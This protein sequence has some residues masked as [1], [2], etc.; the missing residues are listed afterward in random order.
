MYYPVLDIATYLGPTQEIVWA[1]SRSAPDL[2]KEFNS[3]IERFRKTKKYQGLYDKYFVSGRI[4]RIRGSQM[5]S[6][7]H[8][9]ISPYDDLFRKHSKLIDWDC[10][11]LPH[12]VIMNRNFIRILWHEL[13]QPDN[14][15]HAW[16]M[17]EYGLIRVLR[18]STDT[19]RC[20]VS[21]KY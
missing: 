16:V 20:K 17:Q 19:C 7:R 5:F 13:V 6:V 14:A 1:V 15:A 18:P 21:G 2:L 12:Y 4:A 8:G 10:D 3:W 11:W 9:K